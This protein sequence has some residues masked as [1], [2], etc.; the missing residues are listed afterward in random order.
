MSNEKKTK[1][2]RQY[3]N[4]LAGALSLTMG[5]KVAL[6]KELKASVQEE[7]DEKT[8][9]AKAAESLLKDI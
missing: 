4:I 2:P 5:E 9:A 3:E 6:I 7:A 1:T 8:S